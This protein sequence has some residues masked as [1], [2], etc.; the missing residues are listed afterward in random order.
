VIKARFTHN[1]RI[2]GSEN[3]HVSLEHARD[4]PKVNVFYALSKERV[5]GPFFFMGTTTIG[6]VYLDVL[7]HFLIP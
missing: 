6:I 2:S 1:C 7:Q 4:S 5:Y 3:P